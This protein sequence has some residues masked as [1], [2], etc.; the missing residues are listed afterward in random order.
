MNIPLYK[1]QEIS[2]DFLRN[3]KRVFDMS[4]PGTGKTRA[5]LEAIK[6]H[7]DNN[8][9][10]ALIV[11]PKS[12]MFPAWGNDIQK[13]TPV[14]TYSLAYAKN[15]E[16]AFVEDAD[17]YIIN[18]DGV[19]FLAANKKLLKGFD[20][21]VVD[22]ST[23]FKHRTSG[24]SKALAKIIDCFEYRRIL[25]GNATSN[26]ILDIWHQVYILDDGERLGNR[27]FQF[28]AATTEPIQVGPGSNHISWVDKPGI[29]DAVGDLISDI[30]IRHN[31]EQCIDIP[32]HSI[33]NVTFKLSSKHEAKYNIM[34]ELALLQLKDG[35]ITSINAAALTNK[36]LQL[37]SG[38]VYDDDGNT[39]LIDS[40]RYNLI[41]D[42]VE[43]R[44]H[45]LVVFN[46]KHQR[47]KLLELAKTR[48]ITTAVID[49]E[50]KDKDRSK[51]VEDFQAG[52]VQMMLAHPASAA[53]GLTLTKGTTTIWASPTYDAEKYMQMNRRIYRAGQTMKTE[54]LHICAENTLESAVYEKLSGKLDKMYSLLDILETE[55]A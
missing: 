47:D 5:H 27:F 20:Y 33:H 28:R 45:T 26:T 12:I 16:K 30:T 50:T 37:A 35:E 51:A 21:I 1:H 42:L 29:S 13:F 10:K 41:L 48:K 49:G 19:K 34:K 11:C 8:G 46:W 23:A 52:K 53:H 6:E 54:T 32:E 25:S 55:L 9:G 2:I 22:E 43:Q 3:N 4:D 31:F 17:I 38:S 36:L 7:R 24:R 44:K 15:R 18:H 14:L 40:D 39:V